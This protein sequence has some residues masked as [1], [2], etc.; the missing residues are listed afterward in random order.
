MRFLW[1]WKTFYWHLGQYDDVCHTRRVAYNNHCPSKF[2]FKIDTMLEMKVF[3]RYYLPRQVLG[4]GISNLSGILGVFSES[5]YPGAA[6]GEDK[7]PP[8]GSALSVKLTRSS[9]LPLRDSCSPPASTLVNICFVECT[10]SANAQCAAKLYPCNHQITEIPFILCN[11][12]IQP[13]KQ[14]FGSSLDGQSLVAWF[15]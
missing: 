12:S 4:R 10:G 5:V 2:E 8:P 9:S 11:A 13:V 1:F 6:K 7:T 3:Q 15:S 14:P